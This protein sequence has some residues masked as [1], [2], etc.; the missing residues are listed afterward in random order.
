MEHE[1]QII[2]HAPDD[3]F[4]ESAEFDDA[5]SHGTLQG[6]RRRAHEKGTAKLS[7][8]EGLIADGS[9]QGCQVGQD[10]GQF[11]HQINLCRGRGLD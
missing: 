3:P 9:F 11:R 4:A 5:T 8:F 7:P 1:K 2:F 10:I 6:R